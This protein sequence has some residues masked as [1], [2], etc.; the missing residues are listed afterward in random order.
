MQLVQLQNAKARFEKQGLKLAAI[1]YDTVEIL[2]SFADRRNIELPMLADPDSQIIRAYGVL[3][4]EATGREKGMAL[5][6]YFFVDTNGNIR[7]KFFE[8]KYEN[9]FSAN[10]VIGRLFPELGQEV[11]G[12]ATAPHLQLSIQQSDRIAAPGS[13]ISLVAEVEL[14]RGVNV[15]APG[16]KD[17]KPIELRV[18]PSPDFEL[19]SL[20]YPQSKILY[21]PA[22]KERVPVFEGKFPIARDIKVSASRDFSRSLGKDGKTI[23]ITGELKYQACDEKICYLPE[24]VPVKWELQ[25]LP[26]D[27]QRAPESIQHK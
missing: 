23:A 7:E 13:R 4:Q 10:N 12:S 21:L 17:Y 20:V 5:P 14:P 11:T 26:L 6:G 25:V 22:I 8:T 19:A 27:L 1:S 2:K 9:R 3:N 24:S 15:Y 18:D 16:V